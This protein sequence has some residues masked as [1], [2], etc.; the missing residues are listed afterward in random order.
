[1]PVVNLFAK[2][3]GIERLF[4]FLDRT[5]A[6]ETRIFRYFPQTKIKP[7]MKYANLIYL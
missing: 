7:L 5:T 1:M 2:G 4:R 6:D 3:Y